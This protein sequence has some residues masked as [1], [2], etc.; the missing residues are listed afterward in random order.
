MTHEV[1]V[2]RAPVLTLWAAI[3]AERMGHDAETA[4]TLGK[5]LAGLNAQAKGRRLGIF[6][7]PSPEAKKAKPKPKPARARTVDLLGRSIPVVVT[8]GGPRAAAGERAIEPASVERYLAQ[9]FGD[10]LSEVRVALRALARAYRPGELAEHGFALYERFRPRIP[11]GRKGWG[12]AG[13]LD[14]DLIRSLAKRTN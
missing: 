10:A 3:V 13:T 4:L 1:Q 5:A 7:E 9:K 2:N 6:E 8:A 12:A 14:L 11:E